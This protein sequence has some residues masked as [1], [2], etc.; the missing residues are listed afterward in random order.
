ML[1]ASTLWPSPRQSST[2]HPVLFV[3][4]CEAVGMIDS[5]SKSRKGWSAHF[6]LSISKVRGEWRVTFYS[7]KIAE[8]KQCNWFP[9]FSLWSVNQSIETVLS[10]CFYTSKGVSWGGSDI[11]LGWF[12]GEV[13]RVCPT[14]TKPPGR[15]RTHWR[16]YPSFS[17]ETTWCPTQNK[18]LEDSLFRLR[19][20]PVKLKPRKQ[21]KKQIKQKNGYMHVP[22]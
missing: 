20:L 19:P 13:F 10:H 21:R 18:P 9:G 8:L 4:E 2:V 6:S 14:G 7:E 3:A 1:L 11:W 15:P 16:L 5:I 22:L 17:L 12:L